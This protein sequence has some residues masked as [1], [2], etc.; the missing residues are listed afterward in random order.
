MDIENGAEQA[1]VS[2]TS[3][4]QKPKPSGA[5]KV[6]VTETTTNGNRAESPG[7]AAGNETWQAEVPQVTMATMFIK[8]CF[9]FLYSIN[10]YS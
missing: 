2:S 6:K 1:A 4:I 8:N 3:D 10:I 7:A 9:V 5:T